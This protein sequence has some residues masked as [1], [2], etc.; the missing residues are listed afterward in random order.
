MA[1]VVA[2]A[3]LQ[4]R[5][6]S[7][8]RRRAVRIRRPGRGARLVQEGRRGAPAGDIDDDGARLMSTILVV[9]NET[10]GGATLLQAVSDK[11]GPDDRVVVCVPRNRPREG[12]V[13]YDDAVY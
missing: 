13:I 11:A 10:L 3:D 6:G 1:G 12:Y 7:D 8:G 5:H 9:A 2:A 4:L